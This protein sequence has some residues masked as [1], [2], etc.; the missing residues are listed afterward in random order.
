MLPLGWFQYIVVKYGAGFDCWTVE[1]KTLDVVVRLSPLIH[2]ADTDLVTESQ[3]CGKLQS[4]QDRT[5][6]EF[7]SKL[8]A[9][10]FWV[11]PRDLSKFL[12]FCAQLLGCCVEL[13]TVSWMDGSLGLSELV[14]V[15]KRG[16]VRWWAVLG[17]LLLWRQTRGGP[18]IFGDKS[19][20]LL[21]YAGPRM[22][23]NIVVVSYDCT[24]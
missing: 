5:N 1:C 10:L 21:K 4:V 19:T 23:A 18:S 2:T 3:G 12:D 8:S 24:E 16:Q 17:C 7:E 6:L 9:C 13:V 20:S 15:G 14:G 11:A 22:G